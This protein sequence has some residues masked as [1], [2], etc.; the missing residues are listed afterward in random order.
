MDL[1]Y[2]MCCISDKLLKKD[3]CFE[4]VSTSKH[5]CS[6]IFQTK[7]MF[8][9]IYIPSVKKSINGTNQLWPNFNITEDLFCY[10]KY[11]LSFWAKTKLKMIL[12]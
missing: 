4:V 3:E 8:A 7:N 11:N 6:W 12:L 9:D 1:L 5:V 10:Q 2:R